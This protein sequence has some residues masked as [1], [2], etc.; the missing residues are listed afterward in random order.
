VTTA[1]Y[2]T[3]LGLDADLPPT[4][5]TLVALHR[6]HVQ[7]LP[8]ENLDIMLGRPPSVV[9][10]DSLARVAATGRA[11]YCFHQNGAVELPGGAEVVGGI[12]DA[13][14]E[15]GKERRT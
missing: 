6:A 12:P 13:G 5:E 9:P 10:A 8:Y 3:R 2:L 14:A 1:D 4:L 15:A 11:G 7:Q